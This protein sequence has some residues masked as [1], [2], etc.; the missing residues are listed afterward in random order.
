MSFYAEARWSDV[1]EQKQVSGRVEKWCALL[2]LACSTNWMVT[3]QRCLL[4]LGYCEHHSEKRLVGKVKMCHSS[5][6][7]GVES[8]EYS[9]T[10]ESQSDGI[11]T[12]KAATDVRKTMIGGCYEVILSVVGVMRMI[13]LVVFIFASKC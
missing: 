2:F 10:V 7:N 8:A 3:P 1:G 9:A 11:A 12:E 6:P 5:I 13:L 4:P